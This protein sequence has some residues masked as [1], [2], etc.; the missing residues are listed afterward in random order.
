MKTKKLLLNSLFAILAVGFAACE[1]DQGEVG[2]KGDTGTTGNTGANGTGFDELTQ[3]GNIEVTFSGTR[4]D[5]VSFKDTVNF[6][7]MPSSGVADNSSFYR[8]NDTDLEFYLSRENK[9]PVKT[10]RTNGG[11]YKNNVWLRLEKNSDGVSMN[12]LG[13]YTDI[14]TSDFKTFEIDYSTNWEEGFDVDITDYSYDAATGKLK[15]NFT[16]T[17][18]DIH[19]GT[20]HD[21]TVTGKVD[22][23]VFEIIDLPA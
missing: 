20:G 23:T 10:G 3:Y 12:E 22:V 4:F 5:D 11:D 2:P 21:I 7:Y 18:P 14:L 13:F 17:I 1:G 16:Y 9:G 8:Y 19:N 6:L 15:F